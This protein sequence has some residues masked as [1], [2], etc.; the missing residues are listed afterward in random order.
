MLARE[1]S[2]QRRCMA[3]EPNGFLH[4][5]KADEELTEPLILIEVHHHPLSPGDHYAVPFVG[6]KESLLQGERRLD[7]GVIFHKSDSLLPRGCILPVV[8]VQTL[9]VDR[10]RFSLGGGDGDLVTKPSKGGVRLIELGKKVTRG[11]AFSVCK[12]LF[13]R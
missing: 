5:S 9:R 13:G 6:L 2:E 8:V 4:S 1:F 11:P 7:A 10:G 3:D 12:D